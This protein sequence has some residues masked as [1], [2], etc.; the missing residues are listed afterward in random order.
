MVVSKIK[1][2]SKTKFNNTYNLVISKLHQQQY[3]YNTLQY[4]IS[5]EIVYNSKRENRA[6]EQCL[7]HSSRGFRKGSPQVRH[8]CQT[9]R[10]V[11]FQ[12]YA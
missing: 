3:D 4:N 6:K 7:K 9:D 8:K 12:I 1:T 5:P 2:S 10:T 11:N